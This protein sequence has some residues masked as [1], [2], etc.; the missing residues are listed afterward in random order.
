MYRESQWAS[1]WRRQVGNADAILNRLD[2]FTAF[3][4]YA[5]ALFWAC[6]CPALIPIYT[7]FFALRCW[8][9]GLRTE[10]ITLDCYRNAWHF[11]DA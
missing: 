2:C 5:F 6:F 3:P 4:Q 8:F 10:E 1:E 11:T 7:I 9:V